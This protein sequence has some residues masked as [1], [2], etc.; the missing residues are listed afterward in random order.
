MM[1]LDLFFFFCVCGGGESRSVPTYLPTYYSDAAD[2][3]GWQK[4]EG[5]W[6]RF[7]DQG[8]KVASTDPGGEGDVAGEFRYAVNGHPEFDESGKTVLVTWT[9]LN[10]IYGTTITWE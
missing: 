2:E 10:E 7:G 4:L 6:D 3:N 5:P 1:F 8:L 9:K